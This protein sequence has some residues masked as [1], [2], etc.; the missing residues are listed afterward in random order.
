VP[1]SP[2]ATPPAGLLDWQ[3]VPAADALR[4]A[5]LVSVARVGDRFL[6][7]GCVTGLE[8]CIQPA[9][10]E[11]VD[12]LE[13]R[14]AEPVFLP[15][16][17]SGGT[18]VAVASSALGTVAAGSVLDGDKTQ[19]SIWLRGVDGWA[20]VTPQAAGDATVAALLAADGRVFAVGSG[21]FTA[22]FMAW[23]SP[24]GTTWQ[25]ASLPRDPREL[26]G[27]PFDLLPVGDAL[28]AW[29]LSYG[30]PETTLW[31]RTVDGT[32]WQRVE[33]PRG[34]AAANITAIGPTQGGFEAFGWLGGGDLPV[35][36]AAWTA[37]ERGA[38]WRPVEPP[39][40]TAVR[41]HLPVGQGSVAAGN[42]PPGPGRDQQTGLV[43][44]RGPGQTTWRE[45]V[46]IPDFDVL[47][48]VQDPEQL[49]RIIV[50]GRTFE[51]LAEHIVIWTGLVDWAP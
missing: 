33:A 13:W 16:G 48:L 18:V 49:N 38:D 44:L 47:A 23:W 12:G 19:A 41:Y 42:G 34:L 45:A 46:T 31:W 36:P 27:R 4:S 28:L 30:D 17:F 24:D 9:I 20:Q 35:R 14:V 1:S 39:P 25:A 21:A 6:G 5:S 40:S 2:A 22:G 7:L 51:G 3:Q 26:G 10:W 32:A 15:Q 11:S 43:W 29:G 8:G 50:I 37:D